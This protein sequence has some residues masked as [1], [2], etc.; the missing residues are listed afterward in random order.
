MITG[1]FSGECEGKKAVE[2]KKDR[3]PGEGVR[4]IDGNLGGEALLYVS[5][6]DLADAT[7]LFVS[8]HC[9]ESRKALIMKRGKRNTVRGT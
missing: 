1:I 9:A 3:T 2:K 8:E 7:L 5:T 6:R 4:A